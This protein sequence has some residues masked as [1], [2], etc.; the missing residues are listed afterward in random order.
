MRNYFLSAILLLSIQVQAQKTVSL[1]EVTLQVDSVISAI[2]L[3]DIPDNQP[4]PRKVK[5]TF[6][7]EVVKETEGGLKIL[8]FKAGGKRSVSRAS[9]T[10]FSYDVVPIKG[11]DATITQRLSLAIRDAYNAVLA[12]NAKRIS[13]T[14]FT[15][16][17]GFTLEKSKSIEGEYEFSP[18]TPSL[19]KSW[20]KKAVHTVEVEF[21][22][23]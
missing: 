10:S 8:F 17:V 5:I 3:M 14:G 7:S 18:I 2:G 9:E 16:K 11:L 23:K 6:E 19:G 21:D 4:Q 1:A 22:K 15:V 12:D 13:L 20:T